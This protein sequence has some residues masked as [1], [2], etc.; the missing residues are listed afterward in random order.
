MIGQLSNVHHAGSQVATGSSG[1]ESVD[2]SGMR[3]RH[4]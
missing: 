4:V 1:A 2:V 3:I